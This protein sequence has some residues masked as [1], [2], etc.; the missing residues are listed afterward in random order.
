MYLSPHHKSFYYLRLPFSKMR[1]YVSWQTA[2]MIKATVCLSQTGM[3]VHGV[4]FRKTVISTFTGIR[5]TNLSYIWLSS[6]LAYLEI[7][8]HFQ[9]IYSPHNHHMTVTPFC[10]TCWMLKQL[11]LFLLLHN[12]GVTCQLL[13]GGVFPRNSLHRSVRK[14]HTTTWK[15]FYW[16]GHYVLAT[17]IST[18]TSVLP[19][20]RP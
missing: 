9:L 11:Y 6:S 12:R 20:L 2:L 10:V 17:I 1:H 14:Y 3:Y 18:I 5:T 8:T 4:T 19:A 7:S 15:A 13:K 16:Q